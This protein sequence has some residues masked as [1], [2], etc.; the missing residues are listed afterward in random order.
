MINEL[1][2]PTFICISVIGEAVEK[3][4][5]RIILLEILRQNTSFHGTSSTPHKEEWLQ[6]LHKFIHIIVTFLCMWIVCIKLCKLIDWR[7]SQI[8]TEEA[9]L[10]QNR[11]PNQ[12]IGEFRL[13]T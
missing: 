3:K 5:Q 11:Q 9:G 8:S 7:A 2:Y 1:I 13:N 12:H 6:W 4:Y 10:E